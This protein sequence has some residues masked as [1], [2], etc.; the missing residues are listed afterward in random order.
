MTESKGALRKAAL[1]DAAEEVLVTKG[2]AN[3]AM[4]DFATAAG[5]R[6]GTCSITS[7]RGQT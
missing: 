1:L 3:A 4:R 2:N 6:I 5:V 7:L